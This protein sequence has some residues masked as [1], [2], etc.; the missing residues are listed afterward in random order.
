MPCRCG[1]SEDEQKPV[2]PNR[3]IFDVLVRSARRGRGARGIGWRR[4]SI[5]TREI[6]ELLFIGRVVS[7]IDVAKVGIHLTR[8]ITGV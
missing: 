8:L 1:V 6:Y 2:E 4:G 3:C 5:E 7:F